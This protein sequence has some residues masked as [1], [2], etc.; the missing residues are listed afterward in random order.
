MNITYIVRHTKN[1]Y[2][3]IPAT[4]NNR[5]ISRK[6]R[7]LLKKL[8]LN[9]NSQSVVSKCR[10]IQNIKIYSKAIQGITIGG[11]KIIPYQTIV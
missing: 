10:I 7:L 3:E 11:I 4:N 9:L 1:K 8:L 2:K 6:N 5:N